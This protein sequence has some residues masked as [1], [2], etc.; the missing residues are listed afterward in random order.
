MAYKNLL[1]QACTDN[2]EAFKRLRDF[3]CKRNG[4]YDYS[5]TGIGWTLTDSSYATS[6]DVIAAN[7]WFVIYSPGT[8]GKDDLYYKVIYQNTYVSIQG[9]LYWNPTTHAGVWAYP[10]A[11]STTVMVTVAST[12]NN[13]WV[14][15]DLDGILLVNKYAAAYNST[16]FGCAQAPLYDRTVATSADPVL[17]GGNRAI[18]L[19]TVP[20]T[21]KVGSRVFIRD[22]ANIERTTIKSIVGSVV[23]VDLTT[24]YAAGC[25]LSLAISYFMLNAAAWGSANSSI[26]FLIGNDGTKNVVGQ[27]SSG[28]EL[29]SICT[30]DR[31]TGGTPAVPL[32]VFN[33]TTTAPARLSNV[34]R[35]SD[36]SRVEQELFG[37]P[38]GVFGWR[39]FFANA[40]AYIVV[41]EV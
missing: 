2:K 38:G 17:I 27:A 10:A 6:Q 37:D 16:I 25:K 19:D 5:V 7:D 15:G 3:I 39:Y 35:V 8:S 41:K 12:A 36:T 21:W 20:S 1:N 40:N 24:S 29:A 13:L 31:T 9:F 23:T 32:T 30:V 34:M 14:Y 18:T 26:V 4:S 22:N 11:P 28:S 33:A